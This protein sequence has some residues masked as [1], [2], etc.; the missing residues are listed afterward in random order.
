ME[1]SDVHHVA[2]ALRQ[3]LIETDAL[4]LTEIIR[5]GEIAGRGFFEQE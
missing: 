2:E 3:Q 5:S 4:A 1:T